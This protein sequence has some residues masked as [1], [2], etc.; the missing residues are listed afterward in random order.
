MTFFEISALVLTVVAL[1]GYINHRVLRLPDTLGNTAVG[2]VASLVL[3]GAG[4]AVPGF[5]QHA[6]NV[7]DHIDFSEAVFHG[8]LPLLLFASGL[9]VDFA[10]LRKRLIPVFVLATLGVVISTVVV[11]HA[12]SF[13][14][15]L[16][17]VE[18]PLAYCFVFGALISPTDPIAVIGVLKKAGAPQA[19]ESKITGES[20]FNDGTGVVAFMVLLGLAAGGTRPTPLALAAMLGTEILGAIAVGIAV[21]IAALLLVRDVD[22]YPVEIITT[23]AAALGGFALAERLHVSGPL[24]VVVA[25]LVVGNRGARRMSE[26]TREHLF[27]FWELLDE[28]LNLV[29]F[30]LIGMMIVALSFGMENFLAA[31]IAI[32]VVLFARWMSV[33][34]SLALSGKGRRAEVETVSVLTWGGLRGGIS[35]AL[36]LSLPQFEG[37]SEL[38]SAA[39]GVVLFS[40]LV[41]ATTLGRLVKHFAHQQGHTPSSTA[42]PKSA[43]NGTNG[44]QRPG[45][46][47]PVTTIEVTPSGGAPGSGSSAS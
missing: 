34:I 27:S 17:G 7:V 20:L 28:I 44:P 4:S 37:R 25:G 39:Y 21:G 40:L 9:H 36:A 13:G 15:A 11:G 30:G 22:S 35:I 6:R 3:V 42:G 19:V 1:F 32:P 12:L 31:V 8:L 47:D 38:I 26:T 2:L 23:L 46:V 45:S 41:Q 24:V 29:L 16:V 18:V 5:T 10:A 43:G 14:L 33:A